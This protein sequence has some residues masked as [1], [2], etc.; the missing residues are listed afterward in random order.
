MESTFWVG[1]GGVVDSGVFF[2][3]LWCVSG[4]VLAVLLPVD[5]LLI[6]SFSLDSLFIL[7]VSCDE[8]TTGG[9]SEGLPETFLGGRPRGRLGVSGGVD[10]IG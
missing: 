2:L 4:V 9:G 7:T 1:R 8:D 5:I 6:V 10:G 3:F